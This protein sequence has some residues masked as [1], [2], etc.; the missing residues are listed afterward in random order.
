MVRKK[1]RVKYKSMI[2]KDIPFFKNQFEACNHKYIAYFLF[3]FICLFVPCGRIND[4][5]SWNRLVGSCAPIT[6]WLTTNITEYHQIG[7]ILCDP[8]TLTDKQ[9]CIA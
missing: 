7:K 8:I 2:L 6:F 1:K 3:L 4:S 5:C 9:H